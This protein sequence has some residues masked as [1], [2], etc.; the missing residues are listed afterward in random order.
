MKTKLIES[1]LPSSPFAFAYASPESV[2]NESDVVQ[3]KHQIIKDLLAETG[4]KT[5]KKDNTINRNI[6]NLITQ[7]QRAYKKNT[8]SLRRARLFAIFES[9]RTEETKFSESL[10]V[11]ETD[12]NTFFL[13]AQGGSKTNWKTTGETKKSKSTTWQSPGAACLILTTEQAARW[14]ADR[15]LRV[16]EQNMFIQDADAT[17][18][19]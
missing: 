16:L 17:F 13:N 4:T 3:D 12:A 2:A 14:V 10:Y 7:E 1:H 18:F 9:G 11:S 8:E 6:N 15:K 19:A 5:I